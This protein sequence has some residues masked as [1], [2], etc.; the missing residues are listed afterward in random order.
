MVGDVPE[1]MIIKSKHRRV[2]FRINS[3]DGSHNVIGDP[4]SFNPG[5]T[6]KNSSIIKE[7][8]MLKKEKRSNVFNFFNKISR[9]MTDQQILN[10]VDEQ[11]RNMADFVTKCLVINPAQRMTCEEAIKHPFIAQHAFRRPFSSS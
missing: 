9:S 4:K 11:E 1:K 10:N 7:I 3:D 6:R 5:I 2:Y 8:F